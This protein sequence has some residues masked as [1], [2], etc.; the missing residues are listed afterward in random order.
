V[1][2][3]NSDPNCRIRK[4]L[5]E[6]LDENPLD[7]DTRSVLA[8]TYEEEGD[9]KR[10]LFHRWMIENHIAAYRYLDTELWRF[11]PW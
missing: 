7:I 6:Q 1:D 2:N 5:Q 11:W 4:R 8:D 9:S 10:N 3:L